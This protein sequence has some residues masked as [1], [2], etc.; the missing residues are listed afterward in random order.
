MNKKILLIGLNYHS[1]TG[2]IVRELRAQGHEVHFHDIQPPKPWLKVLRKFAPARYPA[3]L[4]QY[5][6]SILAAEHDY[7]ADLVLFIQVH[8]FALTKLAELRKSQP[9]AEFVLY[10][11]DAVSNHD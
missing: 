3:A 9:A 2:E 4:D 5:H 6:A 7:S 11:W 8:Q 10:N 1:Y